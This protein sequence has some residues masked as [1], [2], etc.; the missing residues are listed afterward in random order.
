VVLAPLAI[1][2]AVALTG[3]R[4]ERPRHTAARIGVVLLVLGFAAVPGQHAVRTATAKNGP[5]YRTIA[6]IIGAGARPGD[7]IVY[8]AK[9]RAI[10]AGTDYYLAG[11]AAPADP[12]VR[13]PSAEYGWLIADEYEDAIPHLTGAPRIWLVVGDRRDDPIT[14]RPDLR[15][16]LDTG[17]RQAGFW[18]P[19]RATVALYEKRP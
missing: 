6:E 12:L 18:H 16:L 8:P 7:V 4:D 19:K 9:N 17:Y 11:R 1:L 14:A 15:P 3:A 13:T 5:D 2:A 10:R